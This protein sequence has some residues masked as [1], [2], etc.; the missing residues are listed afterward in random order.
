MT[1]IDSTKDGRK[2]NRKSSWT[3]DLSSPLTVVTY[4]RGFIHYNR[5][6]RRCLRHPVLA[7][8]PIRLLTSR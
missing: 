8:P 5:Y 6:C 1:H 4:L 3:R 2:V 7:A